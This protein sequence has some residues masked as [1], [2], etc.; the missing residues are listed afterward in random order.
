MISLRSKNEGTDGRCRKAG[1]RLRA[2]LPVA[3]LIVCA[4]I[5]SAADAP[6]TDEQ[7]EFFEN[8]IRPVIAA[9]C[10]ECHNA[11]KHKGGLR[12]DY[13]G[14]WQKGGDS[15][16]TIV[17]GNATK[18][19]LITSIRHDDP[20]LK[21][22]A[23]APKL[24]DRIIADFE[25][26]VNMGAPDPRDQPPAEQGGKPTWKELLASRRG[27]WSLQPV[28]KPAVPEVKN[29]AW[30]EH[31]VDRFLLAKME[32]HGLAPARDADPRTVIRRLTFALTGLPPT[33]AEVEEF[34]REFSKTTNDKVTGWQG[35][36]VTNENVTPSPSH[37]VTPSSSP[38]ER[39][40]GKLVD[41][42]LASP[43]FGEHWGRHWLDLMRY[44]ETHGSEGDPE[45][46]EAWRYRDYVIRALNADVP[47][48]QFIREQIAGDL[49]PQ[50]RV[51]PDGFNESLL[52]TAQF[53]LV[54]HGFQPIDTLDDQVKAVDNQIDVV[55]KAFQGL[56]VSC[57]RCHDHKFDAISQRDYYAIYGIFASCRPAQVTIDT[58]ELQSKNR[59]ALEQLHSRIKA[60][61]ADAWTVAADKIAARL[62]DASARTARAHALAAQTEDLEKKIADLE[63]SA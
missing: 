40:I 5:A 20:D 48:D 57:A 26:W 44:A 24:D 13:R 6:I 58:P 12:L 41:R 14:G 53:R 17:P 18:S 35:D 46:R 61:L 9:E 54:E 30:S 25:K 60:A 36:K 8:K 27:W 43:R 42:L 37:L 3:L 22:P 15:G 31:P 19:L 32:E 49:L 28:E 23:K 56:T 21:M 4:L 55:S 51:S 52:G 38:R 45:I 29:R 63:W 7:R 33:A 50:P 2:V 11:T 39:A 59:A 34:V 1:A 62:Q 47:I 16:E 10:N